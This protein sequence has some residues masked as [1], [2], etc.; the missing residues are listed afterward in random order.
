MTD[1]T[2]A[3]A[4]GDGNAPDGRVDGGIPAEVGEFIHRV[5]G[6]SPDGDPSPDYALPDIGP[7]IGDTADGEPDREAAGPDV[8]DCADGGGLNSAIGRSAGPVEAPNIPGSA[9][10]CMQSE[11][12]NADGSGRHAAAGRPPEPRPTTNP[13][14]SGGLF[15]HGLSLIAGTGRCGGCDLSL[16]DPAVRQ[17]RDARCPQRVAA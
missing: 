16:D 7:D 9:D 1:R 13:P 12:E 10:L 5:S 3:E 6:I 2:V 14:G 15:A 17:C 4:G 8:N 11:Y